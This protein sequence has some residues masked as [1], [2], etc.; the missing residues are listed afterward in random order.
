MDINTEVLLDLSK[1][2]IEMD[3]HEDQPSFPISMGSHSPPVSPSNLSGDRPADAENQNPG[4]SHTEFRKV[5]KKYKL[6]QF[7]RRIARRLPA[8]QRTGGETF[9]GS[10]HRRD[11]VFR[12]VVDFED[13]EGN[14]E[15]NRAAIR[16][17]PI[18]EPG[19][20]CFGF[21]RVPGLIFFPGALTPE[22]QRFWCRA[23]ILD[24]GDSARHEN[25][26]S[27]H[28]KSPRETTCYQPPMRWATL[29][30]SYQW[31]SQTYRPD[32]HSSFPTTLRRRIEALV[33]RIPA[34]EGGEGLSLATAATPYQPQAAIVNYYPVGTALMAHQDI[35]EQALEQPLVSLSLGCSAIFLMGT[36]SRDDAPHAFLLRSGDVAVFTGPAR[37]AYHAVPRILDD[38]PEYLTIPEGELSE[39]ERAR[40]AHHMYFQ[41][42]MPDCSFMRVD[43][44]AM[45]EEE[46][47]RYWRLCMRHMRVNINVRQVYPEVCD[48]LYE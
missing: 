26:L 6:I 19:V 22:E 41:H 29:G 14:T 15:E 3:A 48:F 4:F 39:E 30:F 45:T 13:L 7:P 36:K 11:M 8:S 34:N 21:T 17:I 16:A 31:T 38:C 20:A 10:D 44:A 25:I 35:S 2:P 5:E 40:Y 23:A 47:E 43:K 27:T 9:T 46:Q 32:R 42:P 28:A 24:F 18:G 12:G 37:L 33:R 1:G